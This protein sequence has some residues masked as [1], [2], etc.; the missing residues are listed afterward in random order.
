MRT[1][2][3]ENRECARFIA[4]KLHSAKSPVAILLPDKGVSALDAEGMPFYDP[5]ATVGQDDYSRELNDVTTYL[6]HNLRR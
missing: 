3:E 5:E 2:A 4:A 6:T 1:N